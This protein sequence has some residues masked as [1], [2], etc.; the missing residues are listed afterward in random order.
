VFRFGLGLVWVG[1]GVWGLGQSQNP[2]RS[3]ERGFGSK[4]DLVRRP[5]S[6]ENARVAWEIHL[7]SGTEAVMIM[8]ITSKRSAL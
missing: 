8:D 7:T 1:F 6:V 3:S 2:V 4:V 5:P